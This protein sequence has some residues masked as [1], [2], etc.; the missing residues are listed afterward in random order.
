M[1]KNAK[2]N[3][4][5]TI[6]LDFDDTIIDHT[7]ARIKKARELGYKINSSGVSTRYLKEIVKKDDYKIIQQYI[8]GKATL[9]APPVK[10]AIKII[11]EFAKN[12]KLIIISRREPNFQN[13]AI[14]WLGQRNLLRSISRQSIFFSE[15]D[16]GKNKIAKKAGVFIFMDDKMEVLEA[17][18]NVPHKILFDQF[19]VIKNSD[20]YKI[21]KWQEISA[22]IKKLTANL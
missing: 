12:Y 13:F 7:K 18:E 10:D 14:K 6:G 5:I 17:M 8:Y 4:K 1:K 19:D 9:Q 22:M 3:K 2:K 11:N 16:A 21:K 20:F 15:N